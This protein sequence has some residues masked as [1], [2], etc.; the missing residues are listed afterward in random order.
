MNLKIKISDAEAGVAVNSKTIKSAGNPSWS[1]LQV[2]EISADH[3]SYHTRITEAA[4]KDSQKQLFIDEETANSLGL[5]DGQ[6]TSIRLSKAPKATYI[7]VEEKT[8]G[9]KEPKHELVSGIQVRIGQSYTYGQ[10]AVIVT[11]CDP[12]GGYVTDG[13]TIEVLG[14]R[15]GKPTSSSQKVGAKAGK[16]AEEGFSSLIGMDD[17]IEKIRS[18]ILLP[19]QKPELV[20]QYLGSPLKGA[21]L[22][23]PYGVGKTALVR[24]I[25]KEAGIPLIQVSLTQAL[26]PGNIYEIYKHASSEPNGAFVFF[27]EI[28]TVAPRD[29]DGLLRLAVTAIQECMDGYKQYPGVVTLAATNHLGNVAEPLLRGGRFDVI[30]DLRLPDQNGRN[31]LFKHFTKGLKIEKTIDYDRLANITSGYSGADI[32]SVVKQTGSEILSKATHDEPGASITQQSLETCLSSHAPTGERNMGVTNPRFSF[33]DLFG[34]DRLVA[35][36]T[37]MLDLVSGKRRSTLSNVKNVPMLLYGPPGTGKT[38]F[39]QAI[40]KYLEVP[41]VARSAGSF[42]NKYVG[43]SERNVRELFGMS[44]TYAPLV[45]FID[46]IDA[47]GSRR[48]GDTPYSDQ[49]LNEFLSEMDGVAGNDGVYIIGATNR[50]E[51]LDEA[52]LSRFS[53]QTEMALPTSDERQQ[54][55]EGLFGKLPNELVE[56]NFAE[57]AKSTCGWSHRDLAGMVNLCRMNYDLSKVTRFTTGY[58]KSLTGSDNSPTIPE[59]STNGVHR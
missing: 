21:I 10:Q 32:E 8:Q 23:G 6:N 59:P 22:N 17:V 53:Y 54:L 30:I 47:L 9:G 42:K 20:K 55:L 26:N 56:I 38:S 27:D 24:A 3:V 25:A 58:L 11:S 49:L 12:D 46:E 5:K 48:G 19:I 51:M 44:R 40:A 2:Y 39:A 28:D 14:Q 41:F 29:A 33:D 36:I 37:P 52:L 57:I 4:S 7:Q 50:R 13:A 35:E 43:E 31:E 15:D 16:S 34:I 45:I 18:R 1:F